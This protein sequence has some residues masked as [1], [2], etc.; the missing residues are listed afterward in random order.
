MTA[1]PQRGRVDLVELLGATDA[2]LLDLAQHWFVPRRDP[3]YIRRNALVALGNAGDSDH[4]PL[5]GRYL[6]HNRA[7]LRCHAAWAL[8]RLGETARGPLV[9]R[10]AVEHDPSVLEEIEEALAN[11]ERHLV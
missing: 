6:Q 11:L 2:K 5:V 8:G 4:I 10:Q 9:E 3:D 7:T 1:T